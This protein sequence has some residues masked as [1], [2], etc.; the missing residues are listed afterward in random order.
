MPKIVVPLAAA[1]ALVG[2]TLTAAVAIPTTGSAATAG[3]PAPAQSATAQTARLL[4]STTSAAK[5]GV[6]IK[7]FNYG[8]HDRNQLD[9]YAPAAVAAAP[10]GTHLSPAVV[11]VHGGSWTHGN[12]SSMYG[13]AKQLV[14]QGYIA[15]PMNY[16]Y[17]Q[18]SSY[19][20]GRE[21][22]Q[23]AVT[24]V[25]KH[26]DALHVD[27]K[28]IVVLGSSAGGELA[29][30]ALTWGNGSRYGAGLI[31]LSAP[32]DL[33]LVAANTTHQGNSDKLAKTVTDTLLKCL[34][35]NCAK[36]FDRDTAADHLDKH[37]PPSLVFASSNEWVDNRST[38][39]FHE[40][41]IGH[42]AKSDLYLIDGDKHGMDYWDKAW[43]TIKTW[44][45]QR[46]AQIH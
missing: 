7:H 22:V 14:G 27:P 38:I 37:D 2:G 17:A 33:A 3:H 26:A 41:A 23:A 24:W 20:A 40:A 42:H 29:A 44:L 45:K 32:M 21:D 8:T 1:A 10:H 5:T 12:R 16:R 15:L 9:V 28:K 30:S 13:A 25:K 4:A 6:S 18:S 31:T 11:L 19:P 34:P 35:F 46:F 36:A 43:P 39:R